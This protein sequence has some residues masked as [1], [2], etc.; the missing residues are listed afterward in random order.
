[1]SAG[2]ARARPQI[3]AFFDRRAISFTL[4][5][6]PWEAIGTRLVTSTPISSRSSATSTFVE[7]HRGAGHCSPS[8]SVVSKIMTRSFSS[9]ILISCSSCSSETHGTQSNTTDKALKSLEV[10]LPPLNTRL[11]RSQDRRWSGQIRRSSG[12]ARD[13]AART[14]ADPRSAVRSAA[15][16][17]FRETPYEPAMSGNS[18]P[19]G[20]DWKAL[21]RIA[22]RALCSGALKP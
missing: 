3:T 10:V 4:S 13:R 19:K 22:R 8:R 12:C 16:S 9:R 2:W 14:S 1:M 18:R 21:E 7:G 17:P 6:S 20:Q 11:G 5:K 15:S